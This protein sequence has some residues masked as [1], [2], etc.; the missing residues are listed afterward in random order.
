MIKSVQE[1]TNLIDGYDAGYIFR[2]HGRE[3]YTLIPSIGRFSKKATE[4]GYDLYQKEGASLAI[5]ESEYLQY[6]KPLPTGK[7]W[8]VISL[9]QHHG[10]PTRFMDWSLSPLIALYFAVENNS[11]E[12]A[13]VYSL[14]TEKWLYTEELNNRDPFG[15]EEPWVYMPS[16]VSPRLR[17]QRGVFTIQP[18]ITEE[19][20]MPGITKIL[21]DKDYVNSI[22][23]QLHKLGI[24]A[25]TI[26]PDLDGLCS[27]LKWSH[28]SGF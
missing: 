18:N 10:L 3:S 17:A 1:F 6:E 5:F 25:K 12:N 2:G 23:W 4:R 22:K 20:S 19:L 21:I 15:I 9:A 13:A 24:S 27:D 16:H 26:Y 28:F 7:K 11:G 8:E 14:Y